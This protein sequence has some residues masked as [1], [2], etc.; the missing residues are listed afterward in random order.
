MARR[1]SRKGLIHPARGSTSFSADEP[2]LFDGLLGDEQRARTRETLSVA[3]LT[4]AIKQTLEPAFETVWVRGELS[5]V[6][7]PASGHIYFTLKDAEAQIQAVIWRSL[8]RALRFELVGGDEVLVGARL[9]VYP[10][11]G[12]Y[13]LVVEQ[14]EPVGEGALQKAFEQLK[15][16][17]AAEGLF[18]VERKQPIPRLPR[19]IGI[20]TSPTGAAIQDLLNIIARRFPPMHVVVVPVKVQG[21]GA[22]AQIAAAIRALNHEQLV[23]VMIVGRGGGSLEDLWAFNEEP[24][25]RAIAASRIPVISA[26]GHETDVTLADF[27]ADLRALTPSEAAERAVPRLADI[28]ARLNEL[29]GDVRRHLL[30]RLDAARARLAGLARSYALRHPQDQVQQ[31]RQRLDELAGRLQ[32]ASVDG[33]RSVRARAETLGGKLEALSPLKVLAR[34][35][36]VT[37]RAGGKLVTAADQVKPGEGLET[38]LHRGRIHS[39]VERTE[40]S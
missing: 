34:G 31:S 16:K 18:D 29:A 12:Q 30:Q 17:L 21:E 23:D 6:H 36:S 40:E 39:R 7:S 24:V 4:R 38:R 2:S 9:T 33:I 5:N 37:L 15:A 13:Q 3:E 19:A 26:V 8:A 28:V 32:R 20:V 25:V 27:A 1:R 35:Y 22:A 14:I 11:R 10:P